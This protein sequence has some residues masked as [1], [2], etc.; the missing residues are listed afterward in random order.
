M[1][2]VKKNFLSILCGVVIILAVVALFWP[3]SGMF[4][5]F[6]QRLNAR[7]QV[8][9]DLQQLKQKTRNWPVV[10]PGSTAPPKPLEQFP[11]EAVIAEGERATEQL[12]QQGNQISAAAVQMNEH[13]PLIGGPKNPRPLVNPAD[14]DKFDFRT[15]YR[16]AVNDVI[17]NEILLA[18][19]PPTEEDVKRA[20]DRIWDTKYVPKIVYKL[21]EDEEGKKKKVPLS[22]KQVTQLQSEFEEEIAGLPF[23][24]QKERAS[25]SKTYITEGALSIS[26]AVAGEGRAPSASEMWY[27][28]NALWVQ[29]DIARAIARTNA[30]AKT[31]TD[32]TVKHVLR[33]DVPTDPTQYVRE[34]KGMQMGVPG[35]DGSTEGAAP[36]DPNAPLPKDYAATPTGRV[37]NPLYDVVRF[38]LEVIVDAARMPALFRELGREN[39]FSAAN[40]DGRSPSGFLT[41]TRMDM[42]SVDAAAAVEEGYVY[43]DRPV[44]RLTLE[45]EALMLR[46]WTK[47][48]M[49]K[50][51]LA[52]LGIATDPPADAPDAAASAQ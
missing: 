32:A 17:P 31:I 50:N 27:A 43:G 1:D 52:D 15:A 12:E 40:A 16:K 7:A 21:V 18:T 47:R 51:V 9:N 10:E 37:C 3:L 20:E 48:Y 39:H 5:T 34:M 35:A 36:A 29:Q 8:Y 6:N 38:N 4:D 30:D 33:L 14:E 42:A 44:V 28:Q 26:E 11:S 22:E 23:K 45:G 49:H 25:K 19:T 41:V 46:A 13:A 2:A 24:I